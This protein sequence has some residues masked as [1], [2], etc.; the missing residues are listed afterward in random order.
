MSKMG[1]RFSWY[2]VPPVLQAGISFLTLPL[3]T[4][5]IGP[6]EYG[7]Y[8]LLTT[9]AGTVGVLAGM[10]AS[11]PIAANFS[12]LKNSKRSS[13]ITFMLVASFVIA[14]LLGVAILS[15]WFALQN[16]IDVLDDIAP[17]AVYLCVA[18]MVVS[19]PWI[20]VSDLNTFLGKAHIYGWATL[21]QTLVG[22]VTLVLALF[23]FK[24]GG[25]S[26]FVAG[27]FSASVTAIWA[28]FSARNYLTYNIEI[29]SNM[30]LLKTTPSLV[31]SSFIEALLPL[32]E[33]SM[34]ASNVGLT[35]LGLYT[36]S[37]QYR[38]IIFV[39]VKAFGKAIWPIS[40]T[41]SREEGR[42]SF[43]ITR[44]TWNVM[45]L[46]I[47]IF[48]LFFVAFGEYLIRILTN[49][50]FTDAHILV[51][52][53]MIYLLLQYSGRSQLALLY[54]HGR[55][56]ALANLATFSSLLG[57]VLA[58]FLIQWLGVWGAFLAAASHQLTYRVGIH[59]YTK[60]EWNYPVDDFGFIFGA[61]L[62]ALTMGA[63]SLMDFGFVG[64]AIIS[65]TSVFFVIGFGKESLIQAWKLYRS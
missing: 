65:I 17:H 26:L 54:A 56:R 49:D 12:Q 33:K 60:H 31:A 11:M 5:V 37:Q 21:T 23:V 29:L 43:K 64:R 1:G 51:P 52:V 55:G 45:H 30:R 20:I 24:L 40:L 2:L 61:V 7:T 16:H 35:T 9:I 13:L 22:V 50:K 44:L 19:M 32:I 58:F 47:T 27:F 59:I 62:I 39:L 8:A 42:L 6:N 25:I 41:E 4:L 28:L 10:S 63:V 38:N 3:T 48:G 34:L 46:G 36:H 15:I 53:W 14:L 57:I 18:T